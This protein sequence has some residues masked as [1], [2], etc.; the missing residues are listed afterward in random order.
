MTRLVGPASPTLCWAAHHRAI[1]TATVEGRRPYPD[2]ARQARPAGE[3][4]GTAMRLRLGRARLLG[5]WSEPG[6]QAK[7]GDTW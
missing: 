3:Y 7:G 6:N 5:G 2:R 4:G 1:E